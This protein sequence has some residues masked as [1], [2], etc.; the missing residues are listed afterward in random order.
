MES[1]IPRAD[2]SQRFHPTCK[3][4]A[5][6]HYQTTHWT[7]DP[8]AGYGTYSA[9]KV[10]DEP[11]LLVDALENHKANQKL[12]LI[13]NLVGGIGPIP[14]QRVLCPMCSLNIDQAA[15]YG[16]YSADKVGDEPQLLVDALENHKASRL[17]FAGEP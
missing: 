3:H 2:W 17:Q 15:G 16:T 4:H 6:S 1:Q 11:Q 5:R 8:L 14:S 12:R 10:G 7:Q 9:D 13:S